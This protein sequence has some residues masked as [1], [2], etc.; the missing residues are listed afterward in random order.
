MK[1]K[2]KVAWENMNTAGGIRERGSV[3]ICT[4]VPRKEEADD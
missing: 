3:L 2:K 4:R 1:K